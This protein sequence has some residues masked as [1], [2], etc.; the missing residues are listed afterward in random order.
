MIGTRR[1]SAAEL[2]ALPAAPFG[3][4]YPQDG[5]EFRTPIPEQFRHLHEGRAELLGLFV[6]DPLSP[7]IGDR[8][9]RRVVWRYPEVVG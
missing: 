2:A 7:R 8:W 3:G 5:G 9:V 4:P 6:L 1:I